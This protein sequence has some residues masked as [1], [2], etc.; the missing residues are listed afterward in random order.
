MKPTIEILDRIS[1]N[2]RNNKE[3]I[4]TRLYRYMLRPDL[5]YLAYKNLYANKGA[6][7][8]GVND[9]TADGFSEEKIDRIIQFLADETY[10]PKPVRREYIQKKQN[11][12]KKRPLGIPTFTD[13]LVQ[14]VLRMILEAVY[15]PT[16]SYWSHGFRP[17]R[18]CHTALK[19]LKK[20][21]PGVSW[22]VEG[23]IRG[24]FDN[25]DH[26][27]LVNVINTKIKDARLIKLVR[28]FLKAGY[29]E[30]W[31][32]HTTYSGCPQGG[33]V[34]PI[35]ANIYLNEL[36]K[37]V[38]KMAT[39]FHK[40]RN[41][42]HTP[43][44]DKIAWQRSQTKKRL[45]SAKGQEKTDLFRLLK[46]QKAQMHKTPC[47]SKT[48]KVIKYIRYADDFII[49]VKGDKADCE[50]IKQQ[51]AD[52]IGQTLKME[53][54]EEKTLIT[55]S[56]QYA[57]FLGYDIR[58]RREQKLK[59]H[60]NHVSRTLNGSVDMCIPFVDKIMPFLFEKS[61]IRQLRDG[62]I[63]PIA[64][65]YIYRCT[66]L[67]IVSTYNSELRGICN[68]YNLASNFNKL[69]YF[70]YL[71]EYSCL[72]TLAGK[73]C[74]TSRKIIQ[75]YRDG[76]GGWSVPYETK[77]GAK[78]RNF[79]KFMDCK[80]I[81]NFNDTAIDFVKYAKARTTFEDRLSA[82]VCELCGKTDAP[83]EIHHVN[84][85]KNLKGKQDWEIVMITKKR[86]TLAVCKSC[87]HKIHHP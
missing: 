4:F 9:D 19:S 72:K 38:E 50:R 43:E 10:A 6:G 17:N 44:Y 34:S 61:V 33:I 36:D 75:K 2:S 87:H 84:K 28:K 86:K 65:K 64:R 25:I 30:D 1:E 8:K 77:K 69:Q 15:E 24:C 41:R 66:D 81:D 49:G 71:M 78:R 70:E 46:E 20:G 48:D 5:Y 59:P 76:K 22:F 3:E 29:M 23:D 63:E 12:A 83:L 27:V 37:F 47:M 31:K 21:F 74:T 57:R 79:A 58:V 60:G 16:F 11:S 13:K 45:K 54:S 85:V 53:L 55:H 26:H 51:L 39:E 35:L 14:E 18:S 32:Y 52:F 67:E 42:H 82:K 68:Y 7:T 56:N 73:H 80:N 62:T 40:N